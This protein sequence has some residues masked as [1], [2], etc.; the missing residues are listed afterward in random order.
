MLFAMNNQEVDLSFAKIV[1]IQQALDKKPQIVK[2][3]NFKLSFCQDYFIIYEKIAQ[4]KICLF[5]YIDVRKDSRFL[6]A[7]WLKIC[8]KNQYGCLEVT[9]EKNIINT[10]KY[11]QYIGNIIN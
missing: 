6:Q 11:L 3:N 2:V 8:Q 9:E 4:E 7:P 5:K 1:D 10:I